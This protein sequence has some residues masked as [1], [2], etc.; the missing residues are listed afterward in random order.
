V[1]TDA[2]FRCLDVGPTT[3]YYVTSRPTPDGVLNFEDLAVMALNFGTVVTGP[4]AAHRVAP[5]AAAHGGSDALALSIPALPG[6]GG[7]FDVTLGFEG[8]GAVRA[9][10]VDLDYDP[11]VVEPLGVADGELLAAQAS[12]HVTLSAHPGNV[13]VALLGAPDGFR[14]RGTL[15]KV[16]FR[17]R[18]GGEPKIALRA[19]KARDALNREVALGGAVGVPASPTTTLLSMAMPNP[20]RDATRFEYALARP[21]PV[22]L[23]LFGVDGRRIRTLVGGEREAGVYRVGWDGRDDEGRVVAAGT[24]F[25][26]LTTRDQKITRAL[27][28]VR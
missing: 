6:V 26:R 18:G 5:T 9:L 10:S 19:V 12:P 22:S 17:V 23:I 27:V 11:A 13:D 20:F 3:D 16:T 21:G 4:L 1:P 14:G 24:F 25:A 8:S 28:R 7:T 15:A 2:T